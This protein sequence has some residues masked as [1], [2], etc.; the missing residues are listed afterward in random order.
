MLLTV[1]TTV[2]EHERKRSAYTL[3][4]YGTKKNP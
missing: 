3:Q 1:L 4:H 2:D